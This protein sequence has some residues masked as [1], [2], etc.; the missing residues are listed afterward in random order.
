MP[1][2]LQAAVLATAIAAL[3]CVVV[4]PAGADL[5]GFVGVVGFDSEANLES[6]P[7]FGVRWGR[8][9]ATFGGETSL[10]IARPERELDSSAE[11]ATA[12]FYEGRFLL[13][14]PVG[15]FRPFV[16]VGFGAI[17]ITSTDPP[18][19]LGGVDVGTALNAV[20]DLQTN[21][22]LSYGGGLRYRLADQLDIRVDLRQYL[23]FS[24]TGVALAAAADQVGEETGVSLPEPEDST[25]RYNEL[26]VGIVLNF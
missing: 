12:I 8:S 5:S 20:T 4:T 25:V 6:S 13:N 18:T 26:S 11:A 16:G 7:A 1:T 3:T 22:A 2:R 9:G 21:S 23:V 19:E 14:I 17:T 15:Q 24:V 10:M